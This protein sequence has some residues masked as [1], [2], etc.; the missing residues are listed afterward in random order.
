MST[1]LITQ[2]TCLKDVRQ[3]IYEIYDAEVSATHYL[4]YA[5]M[6]KKPEETYHNF[7]NRLVG[8]VQQHLPDDSVTTEGVSSPDAGEKMSIGLLD[9]ITGYSQLIRD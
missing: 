9:S 2:T 6:E 8:F 1:K 4:D 5:N 7:F 3:I